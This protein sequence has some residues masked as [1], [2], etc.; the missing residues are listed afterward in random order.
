[1]S[2][3]TISEDYRFYESLRVYYAVHETFPLVW[4]WKRAYRYLES[5]N[6]ID[7]PVHVLGSLR[8]EADMIVSSEIL[9]ARGRGMYRQFM[10]T[11]RNREIKFQELYVKFKIEKMYNQQKLLG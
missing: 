4:D 11:D 6:E 5:T 2:E 1:M 9:V 3:I 8:V 7:E 10:S